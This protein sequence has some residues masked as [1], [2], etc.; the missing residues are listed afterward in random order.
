MALSLPILSHN[1]M[2]FLIS[3][4][5]LAPFPTIFPDTIFYFICYMNEARANYPDVMAKSHRS[6]MAIV[7][8]CFSRVMNGERLCC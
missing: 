6:F 7:S 1:N 4:D 8:S 5:S 3:K 2:G